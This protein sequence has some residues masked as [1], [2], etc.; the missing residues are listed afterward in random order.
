MFKIADLEI[1][2]PKSIALIVLT[3]LLFL[4]HSCQPETKSLIHPGERITRPE[5]QIELD[6]IIATAQARMADLDKQEAFR[7]L[8]F[9]NVLII[10]QTGTL[11][12]V[13]I[14]TLLTGLYG[15]TRGAQDVK[16]RV[17]KKQNNS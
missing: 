14:L 9:K 7:D 15:I 6:T 4:G 13:G 17:K 10:G 8:I 11:N 16:N 3:A 12:P 2:W 5:L 1:N